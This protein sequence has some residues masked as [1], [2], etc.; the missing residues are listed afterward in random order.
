MS[1]Q[2]DSSKS[3]EEDVVGCHGA[4]PAASDAKSVTYIFSLGRREKDMVATVGNTGLHADTLISE[5]KRGI[6]EVDS[7]PPAIGPPSLRPGINQEILEDRDK[8]KALRRVGK[9]KEL[10]P[11]TGLL[12]DDMILVSDLI[13]Y[14]L[15]G[16][17]A[18]CP[19]PLGL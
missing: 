17:G 3:Q 4:L 18:T 1:P 12:N 7:K 6:D 16:A 15:S 8:R 14:L 10:R 2:S 11:I 13:I 9:K 19:G 5:G